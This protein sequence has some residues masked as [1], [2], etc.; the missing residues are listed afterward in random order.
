[1][2]CFYITNE[3]IFQDNK[4]LISLLTGLSKI[5][6][7][8]GIRIVKKGELK[9]SE[10]D[11]KEISEILPDT[12]LKKGKKQSSISWWNYKYEFKIEK[13][14]SHNLIDNPMDIDE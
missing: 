2:K 13:K 9:L 11:K 4:L 1:M 3:C 7:L 14:N 12:W 10:N 8:F 6:S 5:K